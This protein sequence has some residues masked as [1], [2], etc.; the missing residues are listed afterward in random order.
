MTCW[1]VVEFSD[2]FGFFAELLLLCREGSLVFGEADGNLRRFGGSSADAFDEEF[3][4]CHLLIKRQVRGN[5]G[6]AK[7]A[8]GEILV[9]AIFSV[10]QQGTHL[11]HPFYHCDI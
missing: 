5:V 1:W 2:A 11:Q 3:F 10:C 9:D 7:A 6:V 8:R 4:D